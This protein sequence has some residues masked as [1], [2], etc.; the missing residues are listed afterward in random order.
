MARPT[1]R[2]EP[3][4]MRRHPISALF[5]VAPSPNRRGTS[6]AVAGQSIGRTLRKLKQCRFHP[7]SVPFL[8][9]YG[10]LDDE[11]SVLRPEVS[12]SPHATAVQKRAKRWKRSDGAALAA[13]TAERYTAHAWPTRHRRLAQLALPRYPLIEKPVAVCRSVVRENGYV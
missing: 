1:S 4:I 12:E 13:P 2:L 8:S 3:S 9:V 10:R 6:R 7:V 11:K 5:P